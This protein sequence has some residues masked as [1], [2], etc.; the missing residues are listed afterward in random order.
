MSDPEWTK[1]M[2]ME[3]FRA[4]GLDMSSS[5]YNHIMQYLGGS[6]YT[7][8]VKGG[9]AIMNGGDFSDV[10]MAVIGR[11]FEMNYDNRAMVNELRDKIQRSKARFSMGDTTANMIQSSG[12]LKQNSDYVKL[13]KLEKDLASAEKAL[14]YDGM[15]LSEAYRMKQ[16]GTLTNNT[17]DILR[18][19]E[20]I[21][22]LTNQRREIYGDIYEKLDEITGESDE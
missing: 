20:A 18:A 3:G 1:F 2:A 13:V 12:D 5:E 14:R 4:F 17:D 22:V 21:D 9:S 8:T 15:S 10:F 16:Q 19:N 6:L 7:A 11:G